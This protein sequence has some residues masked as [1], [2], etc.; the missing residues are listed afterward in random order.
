ASPTVTVIGSVKHQSAL[1][2]APGKEGSES[3]LDELFSYGTESRDRLKFQEALDDIAAS[4]TGGTDFNLK[5]LKQ[6]FAKGVEL[7]ADN[8]LHPALPDEA[9][10][11]VR[12]QTAQLVAGELT[13]PGYRTNR[14]LA[15]ALLPKGDPLL[16]EA[17]P[18]TVT[19]LTLADVRDYYAYVFRDTTTT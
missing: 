9:F 1:Q 2:T 16:R 15:A 19:A 14:A 5:V 10:Q 17:T 4:E 7:L 3:V 11:V 13:S 18:Q 8:Q 6:Y 12:E